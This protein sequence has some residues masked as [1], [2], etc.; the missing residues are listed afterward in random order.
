[1]P[2]NA[3][4]FRSDNSSG[5]TKNPKLTGIPQIDYIWDPN[6]PR[7]LRGYNLSSYPFFS[8]VPPEDDIHFKCDGL[9]DGF[10]ASIEHKCQVYHH[11]VYGIRHDF[12]CAN[13]TAFDQRT[14]I[15]HFV[16]DVDCE[17]SK[18]YWNRNDDLYMA[19][20]TTTTSTTTTEPPPTPR[21]RLVRP[22]RPLRRPINRRPIDDYYYDDE[23]ETVGAYEDDYYEERLNRRR[24]PRPRQ[25]KPAPE[26]EEDYSDDKPRRHN[27][28]DRFRDDEEL[29][30][31]YDTDRRKYDRPNTR[32][33]PADRRK[34]GSRKTTP[35]AGRLG[36]DERRSFNDDRAQSGRKDK[37]RITPSSDSIEA[38]DSPPRRL[39]GRRRINEKRP[40]PSG[41][42][43]IDEYEKPQVH[44]PDQEEAAE[45]EAP[46]KVKTTPKPLEEFITPKAGSGSVYARPRAPPRIARPVPLN[47]KKKFQYPVQK[48]GTTTSPEITHAVDAD[49]YEDEAYDDMHSQR[50]HPRRRVVESKFD[51]EEEVPSSRRRNQN[52][53]PLIKKPSRTTIRRPTTEKKHGPIAEDDDYDSSSGISDEPVDSHT[54]SRRRPFT[55]R[56]RGSFGPPVGRGTDDVDFV[57]DD[58]EERPLRPVHRLRPKVAARKGT[59]KP[60][61]PIEEDVYEQEPE[62][63]PLSR[64][65]ANR[66]RAKINTRSRQ[67]STT[68]T[69]TTAGPHEDE[70]DVEPEE[71]GEEPSVPAALSRGSAHA[72]SGRTATVRVVKRP[73]LPSR[74]GSPYLPRGLQPVGVALKPLSTHTTDSTPLDMGSTISGVRLLEHGAPILR[75]SGSGSAP[76]SVHSYLHDSNV[77]DR[78]RESELQTAQ[79]HRTTLPPRSALPMLQARPEPQPKI[80]LDELYEND[81]DVTLNDALNPT[82]KPLTPHHSNHPNHNS[83]FENA[84]A[85]DPGVSTFVNNNKSPKLFHNNNNQYQQQQHQ[86]KHQQNS[87]QTKPQTSLSQSQTHFESHQTSKSLQSQMHHQTEHLLAQQTRQQQQPQSQQQQQQSS[88]KDYNSDDSYFSPTD[89]RR[90]AVVAAPQPYSSRTDYRGVGMRIAQ[91]FYDDLEY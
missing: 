33:K 67:S 14:F 80:T 75:D 49:Y 86:N 25:R 73:F 20:T 52:D 72:H 76:T 4:L 12:L 40:S 29:E 42:D 69:S 48:T 15:C 27:P 1:M 85:S 84:Y 19:T 81:Y 70:G 8:T 46:P 22:L 82:L 35:T 83:A 13:F 41:V 34:S 17:G 57:D 30:E 36:G 7:E 5:T 18:N 55:T 90:R 62:P 32:H 31:E 2:T 68:T 43:E 10:Y 39:T 9:H 61:R 91:H 66:P 88:Y 28:R 11:C 53:T 45:E 23:E 26:Y 54:S 71:V 58:Y 3:L 44:A 64:P 51:D 74:G 6:L 59:K 37:A 56:N 21:R 65:N 79:I 47:E 50:A 60:R 78:E 89:I 24:K 77:Y 16:S 87:Y 38:S 63:Q